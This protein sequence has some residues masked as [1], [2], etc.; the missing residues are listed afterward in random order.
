GTAMGPTLIGCAEFVAVWTDSHCLD[1]DSSV[2]G[3]RCW[4]AG[5][6]SRWR[7]AQIVRC[8]DGMVNG[9]ILCLIG[10][11]LLSCH[12]TMLVEIYIKIG[13]INPLLPLT[14]GAGVAGELIGVGSPADGGAAGYRQPRK[15][16]GEMVEHHNMV[17]WQFIVIGA[18]AVCKL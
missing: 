7:H 2:D 10:G 5:R 18:P 9:V 3:R 8:P 17:L 15:L 4:I 11:L 6:S 13:R 12:T 1:L 16:L 14:S